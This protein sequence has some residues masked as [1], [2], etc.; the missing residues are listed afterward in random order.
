MRTIKNTFIISLSNKSPR[1]KQ[2]KDI[3]DSEWFEAINS[4]KDRDCHLKLGLKFDAKN[5]KWHKR[6]SGDV[7]CFCSHFM[8]WKKIAQLEKGYYLILEDDVL[9]EDVIRV[10]KNTK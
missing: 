10:K 4:K 5:T 2:L 8:L 9:K 7:G 6:R 3:P 1:F